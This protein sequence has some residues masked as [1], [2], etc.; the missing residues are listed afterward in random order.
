MIHSF[1]GCG[2][3]ISYY[4]YYQ[5]IRK[6]EESLKTVVAMQPDVPDMVMAQYEMDNLVMLHWRNEAET[7][8]KYFLLS[9]MVFVIMV[10]A[11]VKGYLHV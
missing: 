7:F 5:A 11:Y 1:H 2:D 10:S 9:M 4:K 6:C 3:M 8:T